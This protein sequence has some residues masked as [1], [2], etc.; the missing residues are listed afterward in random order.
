MSVIQIKTTWTGG[1]S[2]PGVTIFN[3]EGGLTGD[4]QA[5]L[6]A[7]QA[8][9]SSTII[10]IPDEYTLQVEPV[11]FEYNEVS[12]TLTGTQEATVPPAPLTGGA[13]GPYAHGVGIRIDWK[14]V[15][16]R[17]GRR[18]SGRTFLTPFTSSA[19]TNTGVVDTAYRDG[20][21]TNALDLLDALA[22]AGHPLMVWSRP[23]DKWPSGQLTTVSTAEVPGKA[24]IL[25]GRRD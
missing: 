13:T 15:G 23:S 4:F 16:I 7:V 12:G 3:L 11:S 17:N 21:K 9:W 14:T 25:R 19:F 10:N 5:A 8:F 24:G 20:T 1:P 6:A 2:S 18:V 22:T